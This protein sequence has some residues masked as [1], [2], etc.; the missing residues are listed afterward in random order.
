MIIKLDLLSMRNCMHNYEVKG[1][2]KHP[3]EHN[4]ISIRELSLYDQFA[5]VYTAEPMTE[6][7][8]HIIL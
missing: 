8:C 2:L 6:E 4:E 1:I 3:I 5:K 7:T